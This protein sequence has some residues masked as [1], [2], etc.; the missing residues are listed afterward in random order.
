M[1]YASLDCA[2]NYI[3]WEGRCFMTYFGK[4][5]SAIFAFVVVQLLVACGDDASSSVSADGQSSAIVKEKSSSSVAASSSSKEKQPTILDETGPISVTVL[6]DT[7]EIFNYGKFYLDIS[8]N[9]FLTRFKN[10]DIVTVMI[11][12]FDTL[13]VPVVTS[14]S[15]VFPGE[16]FL[17]VSSGL[18]CISLEA[19][20]GL[21]VDVIGIGRDVKFPINVV[22]QMK[23]QGGYLDHLENLNVLSISYSVDAYPNLSI[24]EFAN[25][26]MMRTTGMGEGV[27]YRSSNPVNSSIGRNRYADSLSE[28]AGVKTFLNFAA[29]EAVAVANSAFA[30]SYYSKQNVVYFDVQPAFANTPYKNALVTGIRFMIEHDGPYLVHCTYGMDRT[31]FMIAVLEALMGATAEE[32]M[33]DYAKTHQNFFNVFDGQQVALTQKQVDL[34]QAVIARILKNTYKVQHVDISDFEKAD[35]A[36]ATEKYLLSLGLEQSEID[37]L[38][39]RL[40]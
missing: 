31:G 13:D 40:R 12:G 17:L 37:A 20:Y 3:L 34:I 22:V 16:F 36:S 29:S 30:E 33:A 27:L 28:V 39:D 21:F 35:L 18:N 14:E 38:K 1:V 4:F 2:I 26:R 19:R 25:F 8:A 11:D 23:E 5:L 6:E 7:T 15:A 10:G 9:S 24:E 32:I